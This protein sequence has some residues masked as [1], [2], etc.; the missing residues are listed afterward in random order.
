MI[1]SIDE[2][3]TA[4]S[5]IFFF[6]FL[7]LSGKKYLFIINTSTENMF[8]SHTI[9]FI[10]LLKLPSYILIELQSY[11]NMKTL[12]Q[13]VSRFSLMF[14][15]VEKF[16]PT[17]DEILG[18]NIRLMALSTGEINLNLFYSICLSQAISLSDVYSLKFC[19]TN[20]SQICFVSSDSSLFSERDFLY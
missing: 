20:F 3:Q 12:P 9:K 11:L 6:K 13:K 15:S 8:P 16:S 19:L 7:F 2:T 10:I 1:Y 17:G 5:K 4:S 14:F 18:E